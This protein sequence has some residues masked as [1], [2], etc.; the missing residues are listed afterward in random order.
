[1]FWLSWKLSLI[2]LLILP[3]IA[4]LVN[5][6]GTRMRKATKELQEQTAEV[7]HYL[8]EKISAMRL[9]QTFGT[10][11]YE[12]SNFSGLNDDAYRR[13]MKPLRIQATLG[14][15][16]DFIAYLGVV[17]VLWTSVRNGIDFAALG[18][19]LMAMHRAA[20]QL[21]SLANLNN[22]LKKGQAA[23]DRLF[24]LL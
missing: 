8:Q 7:T 21:R 6:A 12:V 15:S 17:L 24:E 4:W 13:S 10:R 11:D 3:P 16:I 5:R 22:T 19:F 9:V 18:T 20:G 23:A 14:P 1:M 2:I